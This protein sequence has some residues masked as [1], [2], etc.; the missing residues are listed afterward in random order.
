MQS[1]RSSSLATRA[2]APAQTGRRA[3]VVV[4]VKPTAAGDYRALSAE[5]LIQK[6]ASLKAEY[7][8]LQYLKRTRGKVTNPETLQDQAD[9]GIAPKGHE[10]KHARRQLSQV[11]TVL[12]E[13]QIADGLSR[14]DARKIEKEAAVA[15]GFGRF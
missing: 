14:K 7:T 10:F 2:F 4:R 11:L 1:L 5:E 9:D 6:A 8:K 13:K 3:A 15:G 12:R